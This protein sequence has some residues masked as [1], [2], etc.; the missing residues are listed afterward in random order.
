LPVLTFSEP[1]LGPMVWLPSG[2]DI[3]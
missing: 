1:L 3:G 2:I